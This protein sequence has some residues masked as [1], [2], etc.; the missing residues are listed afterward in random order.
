M[1]LF[2]VLPFLVHKHACS[3][4]PGAC[5]AP[6]PLAFSQN[7]THPLPRHTL[8]LIRQRTLP[9]HQLL[10]HP[11]ERIQPQGPQHLGQNWVKQPW[12]HP[13]LGI[14][15]LV[16][17]RRRIE[18]MLWAVGGDENVFDWGTQGGEEGQCLCCGRDRVVD[19]C[20]NQGGG[21]GVMYW[22]CCVFPNIQPVIK[23]P[24]QVITHTHQSSNHPHQC[25]Q[26]PPPTKRLPSP[27]RATTA[28]SPMS[29]SPSA[30]R[31]R[32]C[33]SPHKPSS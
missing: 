32:G 29:T 17:Q 14:W 13:Q 24:T 7:P 3:A 16:Q 9:S 5:S 10:R 19:L 26:P 4:T 25:A 20:D 6:P 12:R 8:Y 18:P 2:F 27:R 23:Q 15:K 30:L 11:P 33:T 1:I 22:C 21:G 28:R 31:S